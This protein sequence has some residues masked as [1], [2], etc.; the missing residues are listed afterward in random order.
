MNKL[1]AKRKGF[2]QH[3]TVLT[4]E[5]HAL[6]LKQLSDKTGISLSNLIRKGIA[7]LLEIYR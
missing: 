4:T 1:G 6:E 3:F 7:M 2:T 5:K